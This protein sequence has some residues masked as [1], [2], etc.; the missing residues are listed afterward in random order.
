MVVYVVIQGL[1]LAVYVCSI[2]I[3]P[4]PFSPPPLR[5]L[6]HLSPP[7]APLT[8]TRPRTLSHVH[9]QP[10]LS[11]FHAHSSA[12]QSL[13]LSPQPLALSLSSS[14]LSLALPNLCP[15]PRLSSSLPTL[16]PDVVWS[17]VA[18]ARS[19][20]RA[21]RAQAYGRVAT[22]RMG[23]APRGNKRSARHQPAMGGSYFMDACWGG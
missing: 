1:C 15:H 17:A 18:E 16:S 21:R 11:H 7:S 8:L 10:H 5:A 6:L 2:I 12:R 20:R 19:L 13:R 9:L 23:E 14:P 3:G 4:H 22:E